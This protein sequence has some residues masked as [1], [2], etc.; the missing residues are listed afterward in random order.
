[1]PTHN[2]R[3]HRAKI[4][5]A[6][7]MY[8]RYKSGETYQAIADDTGLTRQRVWQLVRDYK[9][10][11]ATCPVTCHVPEEMDIQI[12]LLRSSHTSQAS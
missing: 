11:I 4:A 5:R 7:E 2:A 6:K 8:D 10:H 1:M 9:K 12:V 3:S